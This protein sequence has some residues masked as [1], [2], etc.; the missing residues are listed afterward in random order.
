[1]EDFD[2]KSWWTNFRDGV[3]KPAAG[4]VVKGLACQYL[5]AC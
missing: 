3:L 4:Q 2:L 1:M 5:G